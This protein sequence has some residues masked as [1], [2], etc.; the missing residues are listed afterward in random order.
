MS[1]KPNL[2]DHTKSKFGFGAVD[3]VVNM[4]SPEI[5][6][7]D[8]DAGSR[9]KSISRI[10]TV[11]GIER[12]FLIAVRCGDLGSARLQDAAIRILRV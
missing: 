1:G 10:W 3:N 7:K 4:Y 8:T 5:S 2:F 6:P 9:S 11:P 12:S